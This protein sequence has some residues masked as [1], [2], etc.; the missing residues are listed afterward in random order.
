MARRQQKNPCGRKPRGGF[1]F[2]HDGWLLQELAGLVAVL[3]AE[4]ATLRAEN[5]QLR[6][7]N[8]ELRRRLGQDSSN[9]SRPPSLDGLST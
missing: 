7:E 8:E 2:T 1:A 3:Q 5:E 4:L 6:G 9:S